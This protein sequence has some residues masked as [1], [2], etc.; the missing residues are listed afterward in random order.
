[1]K[2]LI[3]DDEPLARERLQALLA[4]QDDVAAVGEAANGAE[5]I[6]QVEQ[7]RPDVVLMDIRMPIMDGLEAARHIAAN[8][9]EKPAV[10]FCT[11]YDDQALEAF[12]VDAVDYVVKPIRQERLAH[13]LAKAAALGGSAA[14]RLTEDQERSHLCVRTRGNLELIPID[15]IIFL[16]AEHKYVTIGHVGGEVLIEEP[17]KD[18][19]REFG[20]RF[21]RIHRNALVG[22]KYLSGL[23]KDGD[24]ATLVR[25]G[26]SRRRLEVS[27]RNLP[28]VRRLL[29]TL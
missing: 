28:A 16:L 15:D 4:D 23:E 7:L 8:V 20:D 24:G 6:V 13:A 2:V 25:L 14:Q 18:L 19:E 10:V 17:L 22:R 5:A 12:E 27:R 29:K 26:G 21:V 11:A 9:D 1:M 3:V